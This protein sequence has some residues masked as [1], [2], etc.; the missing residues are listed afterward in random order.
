MSQPAMGIALLD[1]DPS[2]YMPDNMIC[3][4]IKQAIDAIK[5]ACPPFKDIGF[6]LNL[7]VISVFNNSE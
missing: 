2:P 5:I 7:F 6:I 1:F 3:H 4:T